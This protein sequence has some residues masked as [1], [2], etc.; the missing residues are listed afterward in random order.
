M[1]LQF[2]LFCGWMTLAF[3]DSHFNDGGFFVFMILGGLHWFVMGTMM[4]GEQPMVSLRVRR[5]LPR[6]HLGRV[7]LTWFNPGPGTG[8][9]F[10]VAG[11]MGVMLL[12]A[13]GVACARVWPEHAMRFGRNSLMTVLCFGFLGLC[14]TVFFLGLCLLII[15]GVRRFSSAGIMTAILLQGLLVMFFC[16]VPLI[17][18]YTSPT[19]SQIDDYT[20]FEIGNAIYTLAYIADQGMPIGFTHVL[21]TVVPVAALLVLIANVPGLAKELAYVR[22]VAPERVLE[23]DAELAAQPAKPQARS[24]ATPWDDKSPDSQE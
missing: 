22:V 23:E 20:V 17:V 24:A 11:L 1:L 5:R 19:Y 3:I 10:A 21:L 12:A 7:F 6:S 9:I 4:I 8:Y 2:V 13:A 15:R 18:H 16:L 14:Y